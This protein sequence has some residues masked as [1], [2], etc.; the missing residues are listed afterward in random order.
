MLRFVDAARERIRELIAITIMNKKAE[1][2]RLFP[3]HVDHVF[4]IVGP[5]LDEALV[6]IK[7]I[8]LVLS[9]ALEVRE[10]VREGEFRFDWLD[11]W[12]SDPA[13]ENVARIR[14]SRD[15]EYSIV[16]SSI[17]SGPNCRENRATR[18]GAS[19]SAMVTRGP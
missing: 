19:C 14:S 18:P 3:E 7:G 8:R 15:S 10:H 6:S 17:G 13:S 9:L 2:K 12:V 16:A 11:R 1:G 4:Q 5:F